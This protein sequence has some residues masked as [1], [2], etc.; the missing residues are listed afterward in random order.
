MRSKFTALLLSTFAVVTLTASPSYAQ[1]TPRAKA[2]N[3]A[4][5]QSEPFT[6]VMGDAH[7]TVPHTQHQAVWAACGIRDSEAKIVRTYEKLGGG[8]GKTVN[9]RCGH[10]N[11]GYR[12]IR[13][14]H[15]DEWQWRASEVG[16]NWRD[17]SDWVI[18]QTLIAP[19][20]VTP[21]SNNKYKF[22]APVQ[23]YRGTQL[24]SSYRAVVIIGSRDGVI[25]AYP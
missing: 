14:D 3:S 19:K 15:M 4:S 6:L 21:Q 17:Y 1:E 20:S 8:S 24:R 10:E 16:D 25:T 5:A 12:H 11:S 23:V 18:A 2:E 22:S 13:N 7:Y 9:L